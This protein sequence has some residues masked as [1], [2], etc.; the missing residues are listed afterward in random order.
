MRR[1]FTGILLAGCLLPL[2]AEVE[3]IGSY[4]GSVRP[5]LGSDYSHLRADLQNPAYFGPGGVVASTFSFLPAVATIDAADLAGTD[6]FF[7]TE[8][9][10]L[11]GSAVT[12]VH[13]YVLSGGKLVLVSDSGSDPGIKA[14]MG[15][16][17]GGTLSGSAGINGVGGSIVGSG[18]AT[19]GPFGTATAPL[20]LSLHTTIVPGASTTVIV[21]DGTPEYGEIARGALGPGSGAVAIMGDVSWMNYFIGPGATLATTDTNRIMA[22][23]FMAAT[24]PSSVPEPG[25]ISLLLIV[26]GISVRGFIRS[27]QR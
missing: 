18:L 19:N 23:N 6:I 24:G 14:V 20:G 8:P 11:S 27:R 9:G 13:N 7:L 25:S 21:T 2:S 16:L 26:L 12:A 22:L 3:A 10:A 1:L 17:D 5:F 4:A 15:A